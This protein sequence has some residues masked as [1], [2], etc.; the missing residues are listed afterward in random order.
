LSAVP[1]GATLIRTVVQEYKQSLGQ[2][3]PH[4]A[5]L[6]AE[7]AEEQVIDE[8]VA[9]GLTVQ[10][11]A[12]LYRMQDEGIP[13]PVSFEDAWPLTGETRNNAKARLEKLFPI[14]VEAGTA[15]LEDIVEISIMFEVGHGAKRQGTSFMMSLNVAD[16]FYADMPGVR[17]VVA[18]K[19]LID[20]YKENERRKQFQSAPARSAREPMTRQQ[21]RSELMESLKR[22]EFLEAELEEVKLVVND[23][24]AKLAAAAPKAE[25]IEQF[26]KSDKEYLFREV[27]KNLGTPEWQLKKLLFDPKEAGGWGFLYLVRGDWVFRSDY[28]PL[29]QGLFKINPVLDANKK[30]RNQLVITAKGYARIKMLWNDKQNINGLQLFAE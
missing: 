18:R 1:V 27:A 13:C 23:V 14:M 5:E 15:T 26:E 21:M 8:P 28:G 2:S 29:G 3:S 19:I 9:G 24:S 10:K 4:K 11:A 12:D 20:G 16:Q 6:V 7:P 17:G 30:P 25:L 22:E